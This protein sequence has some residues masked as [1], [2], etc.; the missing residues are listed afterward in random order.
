VIAA[1]AVARGLPLYTGNPA[2]FAGIDELEV[3]PG[4]HPDQPG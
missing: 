4:H 2:D 1:T 3:V